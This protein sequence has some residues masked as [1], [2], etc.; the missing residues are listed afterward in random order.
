[1]EDFRG[2]NRGSFW[3]SHSLE[4]LALDPGEVAA[5]VDD[6]G[7]RDGRRAEANCDDVLQRV[8]ELR[9]DNLAVV[10][11]PHGRVPYGCADDVV[12]ASFVTAE[13]FGEAWL[14]TGLCQRTRSSTAR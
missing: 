14:V 4:S 12:P 2:S 6:D 3:G 9:R 13:R 1:M 10:R 7:L 11:R 8:G 5:A